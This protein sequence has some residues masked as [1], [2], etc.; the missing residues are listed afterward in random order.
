ML[1]ASTIS[2]V[3]RSAVIFF[4]VICS[5]IMPVSFSAS[6]DN[7]P[8]SPPNDLVALA[9]K[10]TK[11][12]VSVLCSNSIGS[13]WAVN[14]DLSPTQIAAGN[15]SY[16][17]T[18]HHVIADCTINRDVT[19]IL[20]NQ[21]RVLGRVFSWDATN[22]LAGIFTST[23]LPKL[24]WEGATPQQGWWV[25]VLG[26]PLGFPGILT[27]GIV[28]SVNKTTFKG[29]TNAA[30]NPGN[31]G[32]PVFDRTGRVIGL[33]T[34]KYIN[35]EGFGIFHGTPLLCMGILSCDIPNGVWNGLSPSV[36]KPT[37]S[38]TPSTAPK[39][40]ASSTPTPSASS[41]PTEVPKQTPTPSPTQESSGEIKARINHAPKN[42][43][44]RIISYD[45]LQGSNP[46]VGNN[47]TTLLIKGYCTSFGKLIQVYK[48][49]GPDGVKYP[50]GDRYV[51][52]KW[53]CIKGKFSG[54]IEVTGNTKIGVFEQP[55]QHN[56]T[57]IT[58]KKGLKVVK[59]NTEDPSDPGPYVEPPAISD[60]SIEPPV[61]KRIRFIA[62][63]N[64]PNVYNAATIEISGKCSNSGEFLEL[65]WNRVPIANSNWVLRSS[66]IECKSGSFSVQD[67]A[68]GGAIQYKVREYPSKNYSQPLILPGGKIKK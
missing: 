12:V 27:T 30:I 34:A 18:N 21:T 37:V 43:S 14:I 8:S 20:S 60:S 64:P 51:T 49:T 50:N 7:L 24:A 28:S 41:T 45:Y 19:L 4:S 46:L 11:S 13:G 56:G 1:N 16:I 40:T 39:P 67:I 47:P 66:N 55:S 44:A 62:G 52:P 6:T 23:D 54:K 58:F 33:A 59:T 22:D 15:K 31:S 61:L 26:S 48:N 38:P 17:I 5:L 57:E 3:K 25:G 2:V 68:V 53:K 29:T 9:E 42:W 35:A 10:T 36:P 65:Y 32:G 63:N